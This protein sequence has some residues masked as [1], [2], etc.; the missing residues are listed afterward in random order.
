MNAPV[1][2]LGRYAL[3]IAAAAAVA[4]SNAY[5]QT[6]YT[7]TPILSPIK[8]LYA[9][10]VGINASG[11]VVGNQIDWD[12]PV[13][14]FTFDRGVWTDLGGLRY[15]DAPVVTGINDLG[16]IAGYFLYGGGA[17]RITDGAMTDINP[18]GAS[19]STAMGINVAGDVAGGYWLG[20]QRRAFANV[21]G[22]FVDLGT[23]GAETWAYAIN[24]FGDVAGS[25]GIGWGSRAVRWSNGTMQDLGTLGGSTSYAIAI[26]ASGEVVGMSSLANNATERAFIYTDGAMRDLGTPAG[27]KSNAYGINSVGHVV[28]FFATESQ[29]TRAFVYADGQVHDLTDLVVSGIGGAVVHRANAINDAGQIAADVCTLDGCFGVR[30]DPIAPPS[31]PAVEYYHSGFDHYFVTAD[32]AEIAK[33]DSG[34]TGGWARTGSSFDVSLGPRAGTRPVCRFFSTSFAPKSSHFYTPSAEECALVKRNLHW[35][36]EGVAFYAAVPDAA[37][38][39]GA[40]GQPVFRL[41][42]NGRGGAPNHRYTTSTA[43]RDQMI[44]NGWIAEG[45]GAAG[46]A[47]CAG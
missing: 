28:G 46:V 8:G 16:Q 2:R 45:S 11:V 12:T 41:Y 13:G 4:A 23:L 15:V 30:L 36:F 18:S 21:A 14:G 44:T 47:V 42:N 37:G 40:G 10:T 29:D 5:A 43:V 26:N 31:V 7:A 32:A 39:C 25:S 27:L 34:L 17:F 6:Q 19:Q 24:S 20:N 22:T 35:Q 3:T 9:T 1:L 38:S 33:L